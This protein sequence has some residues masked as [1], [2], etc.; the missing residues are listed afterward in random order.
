MILLYSSKAKKQLKKFD[1]D[2]AIRILDKM[3]WSFEQEN[4]LSFS[5][6]LIG[7]E[8]LTHR[9]QIWNYRVLWVLLKVDDTF[10]VSEVI[11]RSRVYL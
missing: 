11:I 6:E 10:I 1:K 3:D 5:K 9:F 2:L 8:P 4:P 7:L